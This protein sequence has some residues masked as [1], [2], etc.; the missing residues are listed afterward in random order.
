MSDVMNEEIVEVEGEVE[1]EVRNYCLECFGEL[2]WVEVD[3]E[4]GELLSCRI[5]YN[6]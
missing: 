5:C 2:E 1:E 6:G 3:E 4:V